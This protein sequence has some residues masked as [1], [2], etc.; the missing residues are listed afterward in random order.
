M[1][2]NTAQTNS[3]TDAFGDACD[4]DD[5]NDTVADDADNCP[6]IANTAQTNSD[7]DALGDACD[8]DDDND[9]VAD[10]DDN[11]P[12]NANTD[13]A[14]DDG[15][16][17]GNVCDTT[18]VDQFG[19]T[20]NLPEGLIAGSDIEITIAIQVAEPFANLIE[21]V[22]ESFTS[23][24]I[25]AQ[26]S[27]A[28]FDLNLPTTAPSSFGHYQ[29][30]Y[31]C[32]ANTAANCEQ[33]LDGI[34]VSAN[35]VTSPT[36]SPF[37][38]RVS[39]TR[40][41]ELVNS[42]NNLV[43]VKGQFSAL[44]VS[45]ADATTSEPI[46]ADITVIFTDTDVEQTKTV[47]IQSGENMASAD[48]LFPPIDLFDGNRINVFTNC[49]SGCGN[50]TESRVSYQEVRNGS[51]SAA[52]SL[53]PF[54][55][56]RFT[57]DFDPSFPELPFIFY[58]ESLIDGVTLPLVPTVSVLGDFIL[59]SPAGNSSI[60]IIFEVNVDGF[61][62]S[63]SQVLGARA[64]S[65]VLVAGQEAVAF[66]LE[67]PRINGVTYRVSYG[68]A[69]LGFA[70]I[71]CADYVTKHLYTTTGPTTFDSR[72]ESISDGQLSAIT[73][74]PI[75][76]GEQFM[77]NIGLETGVAEARINGTVFVEAVSNE[78]ELGGGSN[79]TFQ[80]FEFT[81]EQGESF[82]ASIRTQPG[83]PPVD[84]AG[85]GYLISV[86]YC[87][88]FDCL[89]T[90]YYT[91][92]GTV[93]SPSEGFVSEQEFEAF[94]TEQILIRA[95]NQISGTISLPS[96][97]NVQ[98]GV[99]GEVK[100]LALSD[101]DSEGEEIG[102]ASWSI[103]ASTSSSTSYSLVYGPRTT[104][105]YRLEFTCNDSQVSDCADLAPL[106]FY[107]LQGATTEL[108]QANVPFD[109]IPSLIDVELQLVEPDENDDGDDDGDGVFN[110]DDNCPMIANPDQA[111]D[112]GDGVGNACE[113]GN[114]S[115]EIT[116]RIPFDR[117]DRETLEFEV[118]IFRSLDQNTNN[119]CDPCVP[120]EMP[121]GTSELTLTLQ[122]SPLADRHIG[123]G[124]QVFCVNCEEE[125]IGNQLFRAQ[126]DGSS[127][128]G[129]EMTIL[130]S[131]PDSFT[132][133]V[134]LDDD[135]DDLLSQ[136]DNCPM[137]PNP[138]QQNTDGDDFGDICDEDDD[139]DL[140]DDDMDNCP[141][142]M[143]ADQIDTDRDRFGNA[144]DDDD[145]NDSISDSLDN[146]PLDPNFDQA[147]SDGNGVGDTCDNPSSDQSL[148]ELCFPVIVDKSASGAVVCL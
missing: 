95:E 49:Q 118:A 100:L 96:D 62:Q 32:N 91:P 71:F 122:S 89:S 130:P 30:R 105:F 69:G 61:D 64:D 110:D 17:I 113:L 72:Q 82:A 15:D 92:N 141:L 38:A 83:I 9:T 59:P 31:G 90:Q 16:N 28:N 139:N 102:R 75:L 108:E 70:D 103:D 53:V 29:I 34:L 8:S 21:V 36:F 81:I 58:R 54:I 11:C 77:F 33:I 4:S 126:I 68:C 107:S 116:V 6:L 14:D 7:T 42:V 12:L 20:V 115:V 145:D 44:N 13:Q 125:N 124:M 5:D 94:Q 26:T 76:A 80:N 67:V 117:A 142:V 48:F 135:F 119:G 84:E 39:A 63:G 101:V 121:S 106:T 18:D 60:P 73:Q 129:F 35:D 87:L 74:L 97:S 132:F 66:E 51:T 2:A 22:D 143:N 127:T 24:T 78:G 45:A 88:L 23:V 109:E 25:A 46:V 79:P 140:V 57:P 98:A 104:G 19:G 144:C 133:E 99:A 41:T 52:A 131:L 148:D 43:L 128:R 27:S 120:I 10:A 136:N 112:D 37:E 86:Q 123:Y 40:L 3:D 85:D 65:E 93:F 55:G 1:I 137:I 50:F 47:T 147:D 146:C 114:N 111:D 56:P 134:G 138:G